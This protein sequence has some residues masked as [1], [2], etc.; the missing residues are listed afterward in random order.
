MPIGQ[1][2]SLKSGANQ[3]EGGVA[4]KYFH[5]EPNEIKSFQRESFADGKARKKMSS[6]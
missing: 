1:S 3:F 4:L 6:R 2:K 5:V